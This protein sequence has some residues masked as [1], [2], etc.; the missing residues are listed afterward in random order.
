MGFFDFIFGKRP[1]REEI[2]E[3]QRIE[4]EA[5]LSRLR[6]RVR[7]ILSTCFT[8]YK[9]MEN[10]P[11]TD[12][13][14]DV[15]D[16]FQLYKTK[17]HKSYR[18]EWGEPYTFIICQNGI[19]KAVVMIGDKYSHVEKV[20]FLI[21]RK[22]AEKLGLPYIHFYSNMDNEETYISDRIRKFL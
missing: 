3:R 19:V 5:E 21:S 13:A 7:K 2:M 8:E 1:T 18:A 10:I 17:P 11:V 22:Y 4:R 20:K 9:I 16:T 15:S 14:G 12:L 6:A